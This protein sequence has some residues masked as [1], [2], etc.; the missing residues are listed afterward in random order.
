[1]KVSPDT[2]STSREAEGK[3]TTSIRPVSLRRAHVVTSH[4]A[5]ENVTDF[6]SNSVDMR[7]KALVKKHNIQLPPD[8]AF[9]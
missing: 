7:A 2:E 3:R 8:A 4:L 6:I 1:M 5:G 9:I